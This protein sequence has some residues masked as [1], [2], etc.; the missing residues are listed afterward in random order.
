MLIAFIYSHIGTIATSIGILF[1][2]GFILDLITS[3]RYRL[4]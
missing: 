2:I 3:I 1:I 4:R